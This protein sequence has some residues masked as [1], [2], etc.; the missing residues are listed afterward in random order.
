MNVNQDKPQQWLESTT[1]LIESYR[2]LIKIVV[3]QYSS[4]G[5]SLGMIGIASMIVG[6]FIL[7]FMGLGAAWW[8]GEYMHDMKIGFFI[9]G[10]IFTFIFAFLLAASNKVI[11][12]RIRNYI[13]K[14]I[15]DQD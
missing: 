13:I 12:P 9:V 6:T 1:D 15:Y 3:I 5:V 10:G 14:K 7:L 11:I 4:I 8:L 2:K